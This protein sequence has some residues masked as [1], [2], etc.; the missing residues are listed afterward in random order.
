[1][2]IKII[3]TAT[4]KF[5]ILKSTATNLLS[6]SIAI[7]VSPRKKRTSRVKGQN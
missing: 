6:K 7:T 3:S 1:M 5:F 4:R 2:K